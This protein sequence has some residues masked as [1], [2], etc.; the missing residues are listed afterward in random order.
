MSAIEQ[1]QMRPFALMAILNENRPDKIHFLR[2]EAINATEYEFQLQGSSVSEVNNYISS[3]QG[4]AA[5]E[6]LEHKITNSRSGRVLFDL[7]VKVKQLPEVAALSPENSDTSDQT[8]SE[9]EGS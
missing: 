2:A 1:S 9:Q 8:E 3:Y 7:M 5:F 4:N 6:S